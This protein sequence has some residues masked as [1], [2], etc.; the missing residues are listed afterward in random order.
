MDELGLYLSGKYKISLDN[1]NECLA[2]WRNHCQEF[3]VL[4]K[5]AKDYLACSATSA[6]MERVFSAAADICG[7]DRGSL[8]IRTIERCVNSHQWLH[9]GFKANGDFKKAQGII[10]QAMDETS[11]AKT[12]PLIASTLAS[13]LGKAKED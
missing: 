11:K 10:N 12:K 9:Q 1:A 4:S 2:W 13:S 8:G 7:R 3:L 5:I 6:S